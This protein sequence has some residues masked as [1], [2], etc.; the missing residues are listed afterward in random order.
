[1]TKEPRLH[2]AITSG[3]KVLVQIETVRKH[4]RMAVTVHRVLARALQIGLAELAEDPDRLVPD[5]LVAS[6]SRS[7]R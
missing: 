4:Y 1:M 7:R 2:A 6:R 3:P 5:H